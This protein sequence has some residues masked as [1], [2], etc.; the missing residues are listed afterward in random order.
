VAIERMRWKGYAITIEASDTV[1][2]AK[3]G[4]ETAYSLLRW[5]AD[6]PKTVAIAAVLA[7]QGE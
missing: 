4:T 3:D 6:L 7:V 1:R 2:F 5:D